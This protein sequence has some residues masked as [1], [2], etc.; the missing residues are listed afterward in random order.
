MRCFVYKSLRRA[1]T[2]IY[3]AERDAFE[4]IPEALRRP[5]GELQFVL[6]LQ[7]GPQ[8]KLAREDAAVVRAN[9]AAH[10]VHVQFPPNSVIASHAD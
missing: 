4:R 3:L 10:G 9:L 1:E 8:R 7:L 6:E 5:L 2:F